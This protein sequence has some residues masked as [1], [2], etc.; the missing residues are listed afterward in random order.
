VRTHQLMVGG[1]AAAAVVAASCSPS[2]APASTESDAP[3]TSETIEIATV[4]TVSYRR[5]STGLVP[6]I[7]ETLDL[8]SKHGVEV[9]SQKLDS[10]D[11]N[12]MAEGVLRGTYDIAIMTTD[13][14]LTLIGRSL[15]NSEQAPIQIVG[16][17]VAGLSN[18]V[19]AESSDYETIGDL[20]GKRVG[21]SS[22]SS[23]HVAYFTN[24]LDRTGAASTDDFNLV[25]VPSDTM[26][27]AL[28][29]GDVEA[30]IHSEPTTALAVA[31]GEA[32]VLI[33]ASEMQVQNESRVSIVASRDFIEASP[34][35]LE[36][37]LSAMTEAA[38][39]LQEPA[40]SVVSAAAEFMG[41]EEQVASNIIGNELYR[42][43][44]TD[45][46]KAG[47]M[48]QAHALVEEGEIERRLNPEEIFNLEFQS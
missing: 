39:A 24:Y 14:A 28:Q 37:Y 40:D 1:L 48:G 45:D 6:H 36:R 18:I 31:T 42:I 26:F 17:T 5:L 2:E 35:A 32:R 25:P 16:D 4:T 41:V 10:G 29:T 47:I 9:D 22:L 13:A 23:A 7:A 33:P 27:A 8:Y 21:V 11:T 44:I 20:I 46:V 12:V 3:G 30:F 15:E 43:E 34:E 38:H 19:V